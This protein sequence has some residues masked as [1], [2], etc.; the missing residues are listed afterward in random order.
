[1]EAET[2]SFLD[3]ERA[4]VMDWGFPSIETAAVGCFYCAQGMKTL[5]PFFENEQDCTKN[6][7]SVS[8]ITHPNE[9]T[10]KDP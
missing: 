6:M 7:L 3:P 1:M 9:T 4:G 8:P 5:G 10:L 2:Q